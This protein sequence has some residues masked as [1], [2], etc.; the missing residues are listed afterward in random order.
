MQSLGQQTLRCTES[1]AIFASA[2]QRD[3]LLP[4]YIASSNC[5]S[6]KHQGGFLLLQLGQ[7]PFTSV[8][9]QSIR[10]CTV[11][12]LLIPRTLTPPRPPSQVGAV[13]KQKSG[14]GGVNPFVA[15]LADGVPKIKHL[16]VGK[17]E[18]HNWFTTILAAALSL[19]RLH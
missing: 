3:P 10:V 12:L 17:P 8:D 7:V 16:Q 2:F 4:P 1:I 9:P 11:I 13:K 19:Y 15:M 14:D 6:G 5:S 18:F